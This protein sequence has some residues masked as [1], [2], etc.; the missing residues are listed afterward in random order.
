MRRAK[1]KNTEP[2]VTGYDYSSREARE[3][4]VQELF[5]RAKNARTVVEADWQR[6]NDYYNG[7]HDVTKETMDYCRENDLPWVPA[8]M[9][10]PAD[11]I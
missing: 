7:I 3:T 2:V 8:N 5:H 11:S 9:P 10:D 1:R 6:F 4:T